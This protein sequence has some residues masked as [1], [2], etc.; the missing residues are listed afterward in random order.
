MR[1]QPRLNKRSETKTQ[2]FPGGCLANLQQYTLYHASSPLTSLRQA[3]R[4]KLGPRALD[5]SKSHLSILGG[6]PPLPLENIASKGNGACSTVNLRY[7]VRPRH[8]FFLYK[9][10]SLGNSG[11]QETTGKLQSPF[12]EKLPLSRLSQKGVIFE[13]FTALALLILNAPKENKG[14]S[15]GTHSYYDRKR[16]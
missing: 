13:F 9:K 11:R 2:T 15:F 14:S 1:E 5:V 4:G 10:S 12:P 7:I 8:S 3:S 6:I 16:K